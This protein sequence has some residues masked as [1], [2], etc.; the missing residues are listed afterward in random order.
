MKWVHVSGGMH[1]LRCVSMHT[2]HTSM[3]MLERAA[4]GR[5]WGEGI[6]ETRACL[7]PTDHD[8]YE[9]GPL[10]AKLLHLRHPSGA[11]RNLGVRGSDPHFIDE[12]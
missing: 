3:D 1:E 4:E 10:W 12:K 5:G 9:Y 7:P 11:H 2:V 6:S 8:P